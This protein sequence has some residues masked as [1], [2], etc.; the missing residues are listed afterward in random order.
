MLDVFKFLLGIVS[1]ASLAAFLIVTFISTFPNQRRRFY[2]FF[3]CI[4]DDTPRWDPIYAKSLR[5]RASKAERWRAFTLIS[6]CAVFLGISVYAGVTQ[7]LWWIPRSFGFVDEYDDCT[8]YVGYVAAILC[9]V[10]PGVL[11]EWSLLLIRQSDGWRQY[12]EEHYRFTESISRINVSN[13]SNS[14]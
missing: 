9:V 1:T 4:F 5:A 12:K 13:N 8:S 14:K 6:L 10:M 11:L 7:A 2:R 3:S